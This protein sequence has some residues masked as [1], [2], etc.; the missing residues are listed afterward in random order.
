MIKTE[1]TGTQSQL[2][3]LCVESPV[4]LQLRAK[5]FQ[6]VVEEKT[7]YIDIKLLKTNIKQSDPLVN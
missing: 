4:L 1:K 5:I 3:H 2:K 6:K 7:I